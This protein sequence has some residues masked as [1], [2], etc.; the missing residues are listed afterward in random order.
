MKVDVKLLNTQVKEYETQLKEKNRLYAILEKTVADQ[1]ILIE[2]LKEEN[3]EFIQ[4][5][6]QFI[7]N[8]GHKSIE[9]SDKNQ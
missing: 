8:G 7:L 4:R 2:S 6:N 5:E 9:R 3:K 1:Q